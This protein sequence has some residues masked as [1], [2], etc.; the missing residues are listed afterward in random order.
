MRVDCGEWCGAAGWHASMR[1]FDAAGTDL[2]NSALLRWSWIG[3]SVGVG[4]S[5]E[6]WCDCFWLW[7]GCGNNHTKLK[8]WGDWVCGLSPR[9]ESGKRDEMA[10]GRSCRTEA[11]AVREGRIAGRGAESTYQV[12]SLCRVGD[13]PVSQAE[14]K[15]RL[16]MT[17]CIVSAG[18]ITCYGDE[19]WLGWFAGA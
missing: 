2:Q 9:G 15:Q 19:G 7:E 13:N 1:S 11:K 18:L 5:R 8:G 4:W 16:E 3:C 10:V 6:V 12:I 14:D 17:A